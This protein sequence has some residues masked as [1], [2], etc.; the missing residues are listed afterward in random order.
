MALPVGFGLS[1]SQHITSSTPTHHA[2]YRSPRPAPQGSGPY[3]THTHS[4]PSWN[5]S[6]CKVPS[7]QALECTVMRTP[8]LNRSLAKA[9]RP[10]NAVNWL[11]TLTHRTIHRRPTQPLGTLG[12]APMANGPH[13]SLQLPPTGASTHTRTRPLWG[14]GGSRR[15]P[16]SMCT[17]TTSGTL[18]PAELPIC[19]HTC[20]YTCA[21]ISD[22]PHTHVHTVPGVD[23]PQ[24]SHASESAV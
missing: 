15:T 18:V 10:S 20:A 24:L 19:A 16:R 1:F 11:R 8:T 12:S 21:L 23:P 9:Q 13:G 22:Y 14:T 5:N 17:C 3:H 2:T 6:S 4:S 7:F